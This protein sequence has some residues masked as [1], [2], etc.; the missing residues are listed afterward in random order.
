[1]YGWSNQDLVDYVNWATEPSMTGACAEMLTSNADWRDSTCTLTRN[2]VCKMQQCKLSLV[3]H[4]YDETFAN[5]VAYSKLREWKNQY[6]IGPLIWASHFLGK[7][8][9]TWDQSSPR[10]ILSYRP[11]SVISTFV[12]HVN[13]FIL[14]LMPE[15]GA[16][17]KCL[18]KCLKLKIRKYWIDL[19]DIDVKLMFY[20]QVINYILCGSS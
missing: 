8:L 1:M 20:L 9:A 18:L 3:V 2:V 4:I 5:C 17:D 11:S 19:W 14:G 7:K 6:S 16:V 13:F 15:E 10:T 12:M